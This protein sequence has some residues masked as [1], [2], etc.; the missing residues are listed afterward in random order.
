MSLSFAAHA[1][2]A[3][4]SALVIAGLLAIAAFCLA[5]SAA[6]GVGSPSAA[7]MIIGS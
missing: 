5:L 7:A 2:P 1:K 3:H 6:F 4:G